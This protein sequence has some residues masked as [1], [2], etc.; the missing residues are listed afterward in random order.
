MQDIVEPIHTSPMNTINNGF[1][2]LHNQ[3]NQSFIKAHQLV[4]HT[5]PDLIKQMIEQKVW[6][7]KNHSNFGEYALD[8]SSNGLNISN[9]NKLWLLKRMMDSYGQHSHEWGDVLN[10]V[11]GSA[12]QYAKENKIQIR[13]LHRSLDHPDTNQNTTSDDAITYLPSRAKS[14]DGQLLKLRHTDQESYHKVTNGEMNL[15]DAFPKNPRKYV[16]PI[17][18][19]KNKF[20]SLSSSDREAFIAWIEQQKE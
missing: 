2:D 7:E 5:L 20:N 1:D 6:H 18:W 15:K 10:A 17:E 9:N 12:R 8:S 3:V 4:F 16:E 13:S 14:D 19:V 11:D